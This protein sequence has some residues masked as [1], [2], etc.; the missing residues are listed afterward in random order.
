MN[1]ATRHDYQVGSTFKPYVFASAVQN[2]STTQ[3]GRRI[4]PGTVYDGSNH[5]EV[6]GPDGPVGYAPANED[7]RGYGNITVSTATNKSVNAVYA[8][9]AEDVGPAKVKTHR[10]RPRPARRPPRA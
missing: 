9:M 4:T 10:D 1:N 6:Q 3:D 5:R 7:D 8:Q 2:D